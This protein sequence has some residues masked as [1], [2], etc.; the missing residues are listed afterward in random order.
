M[1][2]NGD[3]KVVPLGK[4][5]ADIEQSHGPVVF[6]VRLHSDGHLD[7]TYTSP[8]ADPMMSELVLRGT[9]DK[10]REA[11]LQRA[12]EPRIVRV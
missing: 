2:V 11:I 7:W 4:P 3:G 10:V 9:L 8:A 1:S 6:S 12:T 5:G